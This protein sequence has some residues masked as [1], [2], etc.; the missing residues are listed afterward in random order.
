M[1]FDY[2]ACDREGRARRGVLE[3][4]SLRQARDR[5]R[6]KGWQ[7]LAVQARRRSALAGLLAGRWM[8]GVG[9]GDKAPQ[10]RLK[11]ALL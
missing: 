1:K 8:S 10:T 9:S 2:R 4:D 3:A 7:V 6:E 11:A 5:L